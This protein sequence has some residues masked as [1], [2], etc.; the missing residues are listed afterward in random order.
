MPN[1][2]FFIDWKNIGLDGKAPVKVNVSINSKNVGKTVTRIKPAYWYL[3][4]TRKKSTEPANTE[5]TPAPDIDTGA[6]NGTKKKADHRKK[7]GKTL[8]AK[9]EEIEQ[10]CK[11]GGYSDPDYDQDKTNQLLHDFKTDLSAF[12]QQ[13][14]K[15]KITITPELVKGY[16][17]GEKVNTSEKKDFFQAWDEFVIWGEKIKDKKANTNKNIKAVGNLLKIFRDSKQFD[18]TFENITLDFFEKLKDYM[19]VEKDYSERYFASSI[20]KLKAFL[21]SDFAAKYYQGTEHKKFKAIDEPGTLIYLTFDEVK[22]LY[23]HKFENPKHD[24]VKDIFVFA[25]LTGLRISDWKKLN[26]ANIVGDML[27]KKVKKTTR[28]LELPLLPEA[29]A[30]IEKYKHQY[31]VLPKISEQKFNEYI[32]QACEIAKINALVEVEPKRKSEAPQTYKKWQLVSS[33]VAR[34]TFVTGM[35]KRGFEIKLIMEFAGIKDQRTLNRY[36]HLDNDYKREQL[37]KWGSL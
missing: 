20:R 4:E 19:L 2:T 25:A 26:R 27:V 8:N 30:I 1:I 31:R 29:L 17:K 10:Y 37:K 14:A 21:N 9:G 36:L 6:A 35:V 15:E 18:L 12:F 13:C 16:F 11:A 32:K 5:N 22:M 24:R 28:F 34:K 23:N 7:P 33:H 3:K